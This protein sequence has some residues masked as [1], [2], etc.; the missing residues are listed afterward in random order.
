MYAS[1]MVWAMKGRWA[2][3]K[4]VLLELNKEALKSVKDIFLHYLKVRKTIERRLIENKGATNGS[5]NTNRLR[6]RTWSQRWRRNNRILS[7]ALSVKGISLRMDMLWKSG[8]TS[9]AIDRFFFRRRDLNQRGESCQQ[10][11]HVLVVL[12][13]VSDHSSFSQGWQRSK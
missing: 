6:M 1:A 2:P 12:T 8:S 13:Q 7:S 9:Q 5:N 11:K 3:N 10:S 4:R